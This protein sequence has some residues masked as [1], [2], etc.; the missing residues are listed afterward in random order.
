MKVKYRPNKRTNA[1]FKQMPLLIVRMRHGRNSI[2]LDCLVDSGA[3]E[4]VFSVDVAD[5]LGIDLTN[6]PEQI[7]EAVGGNTLSAKKHS[8]ELQ[9]SGFTDEWISIEAGFILEDEIP[10]LGQ[11]G[12]FESYEITFRAYR[13]QFEITRKKS[14][15][16]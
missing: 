16:F 12:F 13:N 4:S 8:I 1:G 6:A 9:V 3:G 2:N 10:L 15:K 7:Y 5:A 11:T 14:G